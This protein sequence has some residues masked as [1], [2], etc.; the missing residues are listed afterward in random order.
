MIVRNET[1]EEQLAEY[2]QSTATDN[3]RTF[4]VVTNNGV[5]NSG[6]AVTILKNSYDD[7]HL[8][9]LYLFPRT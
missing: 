6:L 3:K 2:Q 4:K 8:S 5:Q 7:D 1:V 9:T